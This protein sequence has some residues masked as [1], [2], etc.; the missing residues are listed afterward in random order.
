M[1]MSK[2]ENLGAFVDE[3]DADGPATPE[4]Q[5]A[6]AAEAVGEESARQWGSIVFMVGNAAAMIA[7]E[8]RAIYTEEAC[9]NWG[10][11]MNPVAEKYGWNGPAAVPELGLLIATAGLAVPS[12][13]AVKARLASLP[14][15]KEKAGWLGSLRDW[16]RARSAARTPAAPGTTATGS[17]S[18]G[19]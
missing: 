13:F 2:L 7:P 4:Q 9:L 12:F 15:E 11:A 17:A 3:I 16:W 19:V 5:E 14:A 8:L 6:T 1:D 10:R 18:D